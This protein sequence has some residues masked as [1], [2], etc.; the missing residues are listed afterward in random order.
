MFLHAPFL[1]LVA[2]R[3]FLFS[4]CTLYSLPISSF[5]PCSWRFP[6]LPL[7]LSSPF[8]PHPFVPHFHHH[9]P[10]FPSHPFLFSSLLSRHTLVYSLCSPALVSSPSLPILHSYTSFLF[11][12]THFPLSLPLNHF[13][14]FPFPFL[15]L[16]LLFLGY[17]VM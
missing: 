8:L 9:D 4:S 14:F 13:R 6:F 17:Y 16:P 1:S 10:L 15:P 5:T 11:F 3:P 7:S 2:S 12:S